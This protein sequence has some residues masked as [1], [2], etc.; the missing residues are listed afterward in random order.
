V[1]PVQSHRPEMRNEQR[2][3]RLMHL[4]SGWHL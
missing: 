4:I 3:Y 2:G 1:I